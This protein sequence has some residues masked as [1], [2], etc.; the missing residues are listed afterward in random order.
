MAGARELPPDDVLVSRLRE[1]HEETFALVL[2]SWSGGMMR[3]AMSFVST[4]ASAEE[5]VQDTW[6]A[7][8]KGIGGFEGRSSLKTWVY[9]ILVNTAKARGTKESRTVPLG[10]LLTEEEGPT[11]DPSRFRGA[12]E[13]YAGHWAVGQEPQPWHLPEEQVLRGEVRG[14]IAEAI[15]E[16]PPRLRAVLVLRDVAGYG[17]AE[18]CS[19]LAVSAGNQR[20]LLHRARALLRGKL[21]TYLTGAHEA[22][23]GRELA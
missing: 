3:L 21:E 15:D 16:L 2:D 14:V 7:V 22:V 4:K 1:G 23:A 18:V 5:T 8:I 11:V 10:S 19:L 13:P 6:L 20:V 17:S 12:G 9:R